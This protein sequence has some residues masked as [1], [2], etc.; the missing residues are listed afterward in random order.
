MLDV[1]SSSRRVRTGDIEVAVTDHGPHDGTPVLMIHGFPDSARLWRHQVPDLVDAGYRVI[2][3]DLRGYGLSDKP[4]D[5]GA[6]AIS[7][8][9]EDMIT[10]MDDVGIDRAHVVG[11]DWG[12][13]I[14]WYVAIRYPERVR[15]LVALSVGHPTA[16]R[17]AGLRQ[18]E[19]SWYMLLFQFRGVAEAWLSGDDWQTLR[20]WARTGSELE[21]WIED[22]SRPGALTAALGLYRANMGPE[23]LLEPPLE[24]PP[25]QVPVMGVWST[26][27]T[28]LTERQMTGSEKHVA[29]EWRYEKIED[30]SHWIPVDAADRLNDLL[31][32]WFADH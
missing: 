11:H 32:G 31:L 23:R 25:V 30:V 6:Y 15:S 3:P 20:K 19:K 22:L 16:F 4:E 9:A 28:A 27:D 1:Y 2:S 12:G 10:V 13:A 26:G 18:L 5:V 14:A 8:M 24:L 29:A 17:E 21:Y 7:E